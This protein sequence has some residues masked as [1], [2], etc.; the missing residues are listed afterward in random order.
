MTAGVR[1]AE[2]LGLNKPPLSRVLDMLNSSGEEARVVGGAVR[3]ALM[4]LPVSD[5]DIATTALPD[6]VVRR[7][8]ATV[9]LC[10]QCSR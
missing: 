8:R 2:M 1:A 9:A 6:E 3:N 4:D 10:S 5:I 7:A